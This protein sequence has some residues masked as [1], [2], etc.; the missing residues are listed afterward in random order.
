MGGHKEKGR[1]SVGAILFCNRTEVLEYCSATAASQLSAS[2]FLLQWRTTPHN[3]SHQLIDRCIGSKIWV[4]MKVDKELVGTLRGFDVYVNMVLEDTVDR[5]RDRNWWVQT[6][7]APF[8][9]P[10]KEK[11]SHPYPYR[12]S[13]VGLGPDDLIQSLRKERTCDIC[14][15]DIEGEVEK[16]YNEGLLSINDDFDL[17]SEIDIYSCLKHR[18]SA[19]TEI[20]NLVEITT[21]GRRIT[22][23]DQI[24]LNGNNIAIRN[25][26]LH[27]EAGGSAIEWLLGDASL[28]ALVIFDGKSFICSTKSVTFL[29]EFLKLL[30]TWMMA[31]T[32]MSSSTQSP[33]SKTAAAPIPVPVSRDQA[34]ASYSSKHIG[35]QRPAH[36]QLLNIQTA[37][38]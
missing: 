37:P 19:N 24:L 10:S 7:L 25:V 6:G 5:I 34:P 35:M 33:L 13:G 29:L 30:T 15:V 22:K 16:R 20:M 31:S 18:G 4:I 21:E 27:K 14:F 2:V 11:R 12:G 36:E 32:A 9:V 23:L 1:R 38:P 3:S 28:T 26:Q 17:V 8:S